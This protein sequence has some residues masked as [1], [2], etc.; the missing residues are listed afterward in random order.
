MSHWPGPKLEDWITDWHRVIDADG[1][2][3]T[4]IRRCYAG[5]RI[6]DKQQLAELVKM[7]EPLRERIEELL[8]DYVEEEH[9]SW[10]DYCNEFD[11]VE[12]VSKLAHDYIASLQAE[13]TKPF[14]ERE[15]FLR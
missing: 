1:E 15:G 8:D 11:F 4:T 3:G 5:Q 7:Y 2:H 12:D 10:R 13:E 14:H 6:L 9:G